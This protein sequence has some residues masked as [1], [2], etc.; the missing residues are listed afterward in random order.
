[1]QLLSSSPC[2]CCCC[3]FLYRLWVFNW[4]P[5]KGSWDESKLKEIPYLY[6]ITAMA[7]KR[8]GSRLV[9]VSVCTYVMQMPLVIAR[10]LI[11]LVPVIFFLLQGTLCGGVEL[12][13]CCLRRSVYKNKFEMTYV[14]LSQVGRL[15]VTFV[16]LLIIFF[17]ILRIGNVFNCQSWWKHESIFWI[18]QVIVKNLSSGTRVV[19]KSH[20]GYE[21]MLSFDIMNIS[22][23]II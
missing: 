1:M 21:V 5:R 20:Y 19:L 10:A 17:I 8:D 22:T 9:A 23:W 3:C 12:F 14:G 16:T 6:T 7:W 4:S 18:L 13:D 15:R 2:C 11:Y